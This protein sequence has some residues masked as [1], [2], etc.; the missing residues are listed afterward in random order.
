MD[1]TKRLAG[2]ALAALV[3]GALLWEPVPVEAGQ[4]A[5]LPVQIPIRDA[6]EPPSPP[7]EAR[8][9][10][11]SPAHSRKSRRARPVKHRRRAASPRPVQ[12][13]KAAKTPQ[14]PKAP[15]AGLQLEQRPEAPTESIMPLDSFPG[16]APATAPKSAPS[17]AAGQASG[18]RPAPAPAAP[19]GPAPAEFPPSPAA[20]PAS[21]P[22]KP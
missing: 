4:P 5:P 1:T 9:Y 19:P 15:A 7:L 18:P 13:P 6:G 11:P 17:P 21:A 14:A 22:A 10:V 12:P 2:L 20:G 8:S 3:G 16:P